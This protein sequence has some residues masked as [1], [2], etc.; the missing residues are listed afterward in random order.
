MQCPK[1]DSCDCTPQGNIQWRG[2][3]ELIETFECGDCET[4]FEATF[5]PTNIELIEEGEGDIEL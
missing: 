5:Q 1:C 3:E 2:N 4:I